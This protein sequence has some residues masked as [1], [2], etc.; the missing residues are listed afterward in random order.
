MVGWAVG[1]GFLEGGPGVRHFFFV[2]VFW[3]F[4]VCCVNEEE[5]GG[6]GGMLE[7]ELKG[8]E[9]IPISDG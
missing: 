3:G 6:G 5:V 8:E 4:I 2:R 9:C 1:V 7:L